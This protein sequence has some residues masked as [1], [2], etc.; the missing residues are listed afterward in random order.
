M[1]NSP[2]EQEGRKAMT[3]LGRAAATAAM[4]AVLALGLSGCD[5]SAANAKHNEEVKARAEAAEK[6]RKLKEGV[7]HNVECLSALRWQ[8]AALASA[9]IGDLEIY[10]DHYREKL[11]K[12]LKIARASKVRPSAR[13]TRR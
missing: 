12:T 10:E 13:R 7:A 2:K 3:R 5:D 8:K 1:A 9:N 4:G 11:D 6:A